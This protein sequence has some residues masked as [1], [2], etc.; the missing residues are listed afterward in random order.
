MIPLSHALTHSKLR[1]AKNKIVFGD[2]SPKPGAQPVPGSLAKI[3]QSYNNGGADLTK[4]E[5]EAKVKAEPIGRHAYYW[6]DPTKAANMPDHFMVTYTGRDSNGKAYR[7]DL[8]N[9]NRWFM[10]QPNNL[11]GLSTRNTLRW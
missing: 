5:V 3:E 10:L 4:T 11:C 1:R 9:W 2:S 8:P 6:I 7:V